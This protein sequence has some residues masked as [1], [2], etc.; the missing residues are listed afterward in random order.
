MG[1]K[2]KTEN[3]KIIQTST[4]LALKLPVVNGALLTEDHIYGT[5]LA[6]M[7]RQHPLS[8]NSKLLIKAASN[9]FVLLL[10]YFASYFDL[11]ACM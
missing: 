5:N 2:D 6:L 11:Y 9:L 8:V 4:C 10:L 1:K 7:S 3:R